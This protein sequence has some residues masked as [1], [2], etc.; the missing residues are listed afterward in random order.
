MSEVP[1]FPEFI[2]LVILES[3]A[4]KICPEFDS[5]FVGPQNPARGFKKRG[6]R[7]GLVY[8]TDGVS[9]DNVADQAHGMRSCSTLLSFSNNCRVIIMELLIGSPVTKLP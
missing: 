9:R 8:L 3:Y 7:L 1:R 6:H 4:F 2:H 5:W